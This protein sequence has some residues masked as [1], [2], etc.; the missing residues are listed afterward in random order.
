MSAFLAPTNLRAGQPTAPRWSTASKA[1]SFTQLMMKLGADEKVVLIGVAADSGCGK[2]TFMR[3][4]TNIFGG[5]K[6]GGW[7]GGLVFG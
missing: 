4:L 2:S 5:S 3:R 6:V 7:V 1:S